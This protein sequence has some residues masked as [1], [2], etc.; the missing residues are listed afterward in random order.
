MKIAFASCMDAIRVP[1]QP[2][3]TKI[4]AEQ[5]DV[6]MLLG[7]QIYM[8]WGDLGESNWK[9][10]ILRGGNSGTEALNAYAI[11]M[12]SRY[13]MQWGVESFRNLIRNFIATKGANNLLVTWD[14]HDFAW[15]N[16]LGGVLAADVATTTHAV[17][18]NVKAISKRLFEQFTAHLKNTPTTEQYPAIPANLDS[19]PFPPNGVEAF[20]SLNTAP[21]AIEYALL[22]TRWYRQARSTSSRMLGA[23]AAN[24]QMSHLKELLH[25]SKK[26]LLIIAAGCPLKYKYRFSQQSWAGYDK[27]DYSEFAELLDLVNASN[28]PVLFLTGDVHRNVWSGPI[29]KTLAATT[30]LIQIISSGAAIDNIGPKKF[31]P[32]YGVLEIGRTAGTDSVNVR[33]MSLMGPSS[34]NNWQQ[35]PSGATNLTFNADT[36]SQATGWSTTTTSIDGED[37]AALPFIDSQLDDLAPFPIFVRRKPSATLQNTPLTCP[38]EAMDDF[39][40]AFGAQTAP[41]TM[42]QACLVQASNADPADLT[43]SARLTL[44][45]KAGTLNGT[46]DETEATIKAL[47]RDAF[48]RARNSGGTISSVTLFVHGTGKTI[49]DVIDQCYALRRLFNTE[50]VAFAWQA[51]KGGGGLAA[52]FGAFNTYAN[53]KG[54]ALD[55]NVFIKQFNEIAGQ[56]PELAAIV[57]CRSIA[58]TMFVE[59]LATIG[60]NTTDR[61]AV[62]SNI[63]RIILS[64]PYASIDQFRNCTK[65]QEC[66]LPIVVTINE[67]D[68]TLQFAKWIAG[69]HGWLGKDL[70]YPKTRKCYGV[71]FLHFASVG[72]MHDYFFPKL[73]NAQRELNKKLFSKTAIDPTSVAGVTRSPGF[74]SDV[75]L[76]P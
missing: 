50:P 52:Y 54:T 39:E 62:F 12:H 71:Q 27:P 47:I 38:V 36:L 41:L 45:Y 63:N 61:A 23:D 21:Y 2:V 64:A 5:P 43:S 67:N 32:S 73:S 25:S 6:L 65:D 8:D 55:L 20:G 56:Y 16:S 14:D 57:L 59:G 42:P 68:Q 22:D 29:R 13:A 10:A 31:L 51:G 3:W 4:Q 7:D 66:E 26:G 33:L 60:L 72:P 17:P 58:A 19:V 24:G 1:E 34:A 46:G 76:V 18:E 30:K 44:T 40:N 9:Q 37:A 69:T 70:N 35:N 74:Q 28:R 75:Y 15:N 49:P 11:E 48:E 53:A